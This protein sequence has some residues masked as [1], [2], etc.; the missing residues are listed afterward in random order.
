[1]QDSEFDKTKTAITLAPAERRHLDDD[2]IM[3]TAPLEIRFAMPVV[4]ASPE[5]RPV[6][7]VAAAA[8]M[9]EVYT[10]SFRPSFHTIKRQSIRNELEA[11]TIHRCMV[12]VYRGCE[13][14]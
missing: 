7:L 2:V 5:R 13:C 9:R 12:L 6:D 8:S 14:D 1:M 3:E 4:A 11:R 10:P